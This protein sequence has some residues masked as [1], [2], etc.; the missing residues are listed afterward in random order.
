MDRARLDQAKRRQD[1]ACL[2]VRRRFAREL[3]VQ[4][5]PVRVGMAAAFREIPKLSGSGSVVFLLR[6][7][8]QTQTK[9]YADSFSRSLARRTYRTRCGCGQTA[10]DDFMRVRSRA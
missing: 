2:G 6:E 8:S 10:S 7:K 9:I 3:R 5:K 1:C 4:I